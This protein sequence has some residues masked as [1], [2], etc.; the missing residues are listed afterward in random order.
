MNWDELV[1][2]L[3]KER[4]YMFEMVSPYNVVVI[5]YMQE[6]LYFLGA[7]DNKT[8]EYVSENLKG[9]WTPNKIEVHNLEE[10]VEIADSLS[11]MEE[12][13]V[14]FDGVN[15][16]KVKSPAY[17]RAHYYR[18]NNNITWKH[19]F[20]IVEQG[21]DS[22]FLSYFPSMIP[23]IEEI[24]EYNIELKNTAV[25]ILRRLKKRGPISRAEYAAEVKAYHSF[26]WDFLFRNYD[27]YVLFEDW[28]KGVKLSKKIDFF[29]MSQDL[30]HEGVWAHALE[31][32]VRRKE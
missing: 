6:R 2:Q 17:V 32:I 30:E 31:D 4:T 26:F 8:G 28:Y 7:R 24:K 10:L 11:W 12:G 16:I 14:V 23:L 19:L 29:L 3:N 13:F 5:P 22:E 18:A 1:C 9:L 15:R 20:E 21:E 27:D 25:E